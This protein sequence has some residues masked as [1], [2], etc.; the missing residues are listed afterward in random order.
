[1][2][3]R[4]LLQGCRHEHHLSQA[5]ASRLETVTPL[6]PRLVHSEFMSPPGGCNVFPISSFP[7]PSDSW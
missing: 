1:L 2:I 5:S 3:A 7:A 4:R 6:T